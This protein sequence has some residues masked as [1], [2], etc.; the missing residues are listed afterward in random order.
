[1][2]FRKS[3]FGMRVHVGREWLCHFRRHRMSQCKGYNRWGGGSCYATS[4]MFPNAFLAHVI[5]QCGCAWSGDPT[6]IIQGPRLLSSVASLWSSSPVRSAGC[7]EALRL[8]PSRCEQTWLSDAVARAWPSGCLAACEPEKCVLTVT[9]NRQVQRGRPPGLHAHPLPVSYRFCCLTSR[10]R[11]G[12]V[13]PK[14]RSLCRE[15]WKNIGLGFREPARVRVWRPLTRLR[16][17]GRSFADY[18]LF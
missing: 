14:G 1:M 2:T 13:F 16:S 10:N 9:A 12:K 6:V 7:R 3:A 4:P 5:V 15:E 18:P 17:P 11:G 8:T